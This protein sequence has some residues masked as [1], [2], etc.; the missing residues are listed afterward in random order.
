MHNLLG[1]LQ[2]VAWLAVT[3]AFIGGLGVMLANFGAVL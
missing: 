3:A 2:A 1:A